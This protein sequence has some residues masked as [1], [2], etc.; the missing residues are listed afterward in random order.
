MAA[1]N[2]PAFDPMVIRFG[3]SSFNDSDESEDDDEST[4]GSLGGSPVSKWAVLCEKVPHVL[5]S[6]SYQK[7]DGRTWLCPSFYGY[8]TD[9]SK[10][11]KNK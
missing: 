2:A 5:E 10:K 8:D 9:F 11:K 7:M 1:N 3:S 4:S 6:S